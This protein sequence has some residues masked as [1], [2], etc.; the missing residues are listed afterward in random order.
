MNEH[1]QSLLS[2][3]ASQVNLS[4]PILPL[5][6]LTYPNTNAIA[7]CS[8]I[9]LMIVQLCQVGL[10]IGAENQ[11][12]IRALPYTPYYSRVEVFQQ[13]EAFGRLTPCR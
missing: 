11:S 5:E 1:H 12:R 8:N 10:H 3:Q 9:F 4:S 6:Y 7:N 2:Q 13:I